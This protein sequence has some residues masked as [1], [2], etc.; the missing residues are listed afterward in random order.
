MRAKSSVALFELQ[1]VRD[2]SHRSAQAGPRTQGLGGTAIHRVTGTADGQLSLRG[3]SVR[4]RIPVAIRFHYAAND[5]EA[6]PQMIEVILAGDLQIPFG[7]YEIAPRSADGTVISDL[8]PHFAKEGAA[9]ALVSGQLTLDHVAA[10]K[11][12]ASP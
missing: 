6:T 12:S 10:P 2:L 1:G 5:K 9:N 8:V 7:E 4:R 3:F 11:R